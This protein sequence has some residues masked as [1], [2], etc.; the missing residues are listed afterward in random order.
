VGPWYSEVGF[1]L[2]V[3]FLLAFAVIGP[4]LFFRAVMISGSRGRQVL[5]AL[6][7]ALTLFGTIIGVLLL[8]GQYTEKRGRFAVLTIL[9]LANYLA[10]RQRR[11]ASAEPDAAPNGGP[12]ERLGNSEVS[13]GPPS[14]ALEGVRGA[15]P[16]ILHSLSIENGSGVTG[17]APRGGYSL[18]GI[19][20]VLPPMN[21]RTTASPGTK[22]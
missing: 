16:N 17:G 8:S 9:P 22:S 11:G 2:F 18:C 10:R 3:P 1:V 4:D 19:A 6:V 12:A 14:V 5:L 21:S 13:G 7:V 15:H 20:R